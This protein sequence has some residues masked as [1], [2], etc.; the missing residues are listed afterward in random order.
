MLRV[1]VRRSRD[2]QRQQ[3]RVTEHTCSGCVTYDTR[4][5]RI[6]LWA[7]AMA[8]LGR[9]VPLSRGKFS[10]SHE[11]W[12]KKSMAH[13][14]RRRPCHYPSRS[15]RPR[16]RDSTPG[17]QQVREQRRGA[18]TR[19]STVRTCAPLQP[20]LSKVVSYRLLYP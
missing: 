1:R 13:S 9:N 10:A 20:P 6:H 7:C 5:T 15:A 19:V 17:A 11:H 18:R 16:S 2:R 3:E 14:A 4:Y 8:V 12:G